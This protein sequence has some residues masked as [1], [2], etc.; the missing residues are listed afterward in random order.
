MLPANQKNEMKR[1]EAWRVYGALLVSSFFRISYDFL[2]FLPE[3]S[4]ETDVI[5]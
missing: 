5:L 3:Y 2:R 4:V 1:H